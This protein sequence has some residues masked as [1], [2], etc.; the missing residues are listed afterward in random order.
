VADDNSKLTKAE[1]V[2]VVATEMPGKLELFHTAARVPMV[3]F[4]V[5]GHRE[6]WP[7][8]SEEFE[9]QLR[10][11]FWERF[12]LA[13]PTYI[14]KELVEILTARALFDGPEHK[15]FT[16]VGE[17]NGE[18]FIDL[19]DSDWRVVRITPGGWQLP[20][21]SPVKFVR[22][23]GMA[24]LPVPET[25]DIAELTPFLNLFEDERIL[26]LDF[27]LMALNPRGPYPVMVF[28]G[29]QGSSKT[30]LTG[31]ARALIDP[32]IPPTQAPPREERDLRITAESSWLVALDNL[33]VVDWR[34]SD[35]LCRLSTGGGLRIR[36]HYRNR[37]EQIFSS[38]R[39]V[40]VN[41][42]ESLVTRGDLL[43]RAVLI[44]VPPIQQHRPDDEFWGE[45]NEARPRILGALLSAVA[46]ALSNLDRVTVAQYPRMADFTRWVVAG[47]SGL[48]LQAGA[49]LRAYERNR[50]LAHHTALE[51]SSVFEPLLNLVRSIA[52]RSTV[53][54]ARPIW[55]GDV[56]GLLEALRVQAMQTQNNGDFPRNPKAL[57]AALDRL[58]PNLMRE[59]IEVVYRGHDPQTRRRLVSIGYRGPATPWPKRPGEYTRDPSEP[60]PGND[61]AASGS[62]GPKGPK[63]DGC[64]E[65]SAA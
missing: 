29:P 44:R 61:V 37:T 54:L 51:A 43:D 12:E 53:N 38:I 49:F 6:T 47:E 40:I 2:R 46:V 15:V 5:A 45:F 50:A 25:G 35:A 17:Q 34:L 20:S 55:N 23:P 18:I 21:E 41:S 36:K 8:R 42:I 28:E 63:D 33:S 59:G 48:G 64:D 57:R 22:S 11:Y 14:I 19:C 58:Q 56:T 3:T 27:L 4:S 10:R 7:L 1:I 62:K 65:G 16:R 24:P 31:I 32:S 39:P 30:T 52:S 9:Y 13:A 60:S 26:F